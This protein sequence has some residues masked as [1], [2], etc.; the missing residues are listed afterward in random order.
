MVGHHRKIQEV[1]KLIGQV[2]AKDVTVLITG[3]SGTGKE[4]V[5]RAIYHHSHRRDKPFMAFNCATVPDS[6][7]ESELFGYERG[8]F[9]GANRSYIG[10]FERCH[11]GTLFFDEI[12]DMSLR[13]QAKVLR[14]LQ[15]GEFERLGGT[16]PIKVDVR[17]LA[18]TNKN[19]E[20]QVQEGRFREDLY[21]RLRI[22]TIPLPPLRARLEDIPA[23]VDY[24]V[25]R[26]AAEY[27]CP[28][29]YVPDQTIRKL[30]SFNWPGNVRQLENCL[31][32][33]VLICKGEVLLPDHIDFETPQQPGSAGP[34]S[35][36]LEHRVDELVAEL[37]EHLGH[38]AHA[39]VLDMVEKSLIARALQRCGYNQV[40]TARMLAI[41]RNT[42]R[43]RIQKYRLEPPSP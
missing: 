4:L 12:G 35:T 14:V 24:F 37:L 13:T 22:I 16:Q 9:T 30:Q 15:E 32:R 17:I 28:V 43:Q 8:A 39:S 5:A 7:V 33:A 31:R 23:L 29:R 1:F 11:L 27:G 41:S 36:D 6:L 25:G 40:H 21:Y 26:Y 38:Q 34:V 19:L 42:L 20:K 3:E 2:A 18:A 10:K